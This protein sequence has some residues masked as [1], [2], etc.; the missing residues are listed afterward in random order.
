MSR[1]GALQATH[2]QLLHLAPDARQHC[3][4]AQAGP[5]RGMQMGIRDCWRHIAKLVALKPDQNLMDC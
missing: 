3:A 1:E 4:L 2:L 5:F